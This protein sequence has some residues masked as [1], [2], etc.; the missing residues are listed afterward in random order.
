MQTDEIRNQ[1]SRQD[2]EEKLID[3]LHLQ[4][5]EHS[6]HVPWGLFFMLI[7]S[8]IVH[9]QIRGHSLQYD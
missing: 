6:L 3:I 7:Y 2:G 5:C 9:M 1:R 4:V 8:R